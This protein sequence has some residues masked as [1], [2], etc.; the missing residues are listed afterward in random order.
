MAETGDWIVPH[1]DG[2]VYAT[3]PPL[4]F[5]AIAL[6]ATALGR[7]SESAVR[8]PAALA[9]IG[10]MLAIFELGRRRVS[11]RAG[12]F[13]AVALGTAAKVHWQARNA[14]IDMTLT[15]F[16]TLAILAWAV[17]RFEDR[18][19]L[20]LLFWAFAALG[21]LAKGP[22]GLLVPIGAVGAYLVFRR[23]RAGVAAL[24]P[25]RG[26]LLYLAVLAA[27]FLPAAIV[28]GASYAEA[29]AFRET[30]VR[31]V[32]PWHAI[33]PW[34]LYLW[35]TPVAF[36]PWSVFL[37]SAVVVARRESPGRARDTLVLA[38]AWVLPT[39]VFLSLSK[40]KRDVYMMPT[41]PGLALAV[42]VTLDRLASGWPRGRTWLEGPLL[43]AAAGAAAGV[44][45]MAI[46][47][48]RVVAAAGGPGAARAALALL[49]ALGV[50]ALVGWALVRAGRPSAGTVALAVGAA[51][52]GIG[53]NGFLLARQDARES[54]KAVGERVAALP[55]GDAVA[56]YGDGLATNRNVQVI[57]YAGR[58]PALLD[59]PEA[60]RGWAAGPGERW[61]A[62]ERGRLEAAGLDVP[63]AA[64]LPSP[65]RWPWALCRV[66]IDPSGRVACR[67]P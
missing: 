18:P 50:A 45:G 17:A 61:V 9:A 52:L 62:G 34:Y 49:A 54:F 27:W 22:M 48:E 44:A 57:F 3:K 40:G 63:A 31:Y 32:E 60:L 19:R 41:L 24:R 12:A 8:L 58:R 26:A 55:A 39:L 16:V 53:A 7:W 33:Q 11:T 66:R 51:A 14:Q 6:S 59:G 10:A 38:A 23:D 42:G 1:L 28:G 25:G 43:V 15:L 20:S 2:E 67:A 4:H 56:L 37:V 35:T 36:L 13:A 64:S 46:R 30:V 65:P 21:T 5:W 29:V 47:W